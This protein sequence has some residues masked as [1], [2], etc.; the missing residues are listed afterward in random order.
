MDDSL[1]FLYFV[2]IMSIKQ[3]MIKIKTLF[4]HEGV[5]VYVRKN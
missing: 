3:R 2:K 5:K 1:T 4:V